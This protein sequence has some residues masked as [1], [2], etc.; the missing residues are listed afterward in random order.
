LPVRSAAGLEKHPKWQYF[1]GEKR[2]LGGK[3]REAIQKLGCDMISRI[4]D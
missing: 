4:D 3:W 1:I 2:R